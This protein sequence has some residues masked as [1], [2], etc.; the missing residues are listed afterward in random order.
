MLKGCLRS[1]TLSL[2]PWPTIT[3]PRFQEG[4]RF[5]NDTGVPVVLVQHFRGNLDSYDPLI[6][7]DLAQNRELVIFDN[8]GVGRTN[9]A[10]PETIQD[11][12]NDT[13]S[14]IEGLGVDHC[15]VFGH[16]MGGHVS[17]LVALDR[18]DLV[19][20]LILVGTGPRGGEGMAGRPPEVAALW[21]K[22]YGDQD[23]M[24]LPIFF[25]PRRSFGLGDTNRLHVRLSAANPT[26]NAHCEWQ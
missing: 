15:D 20:R 9:G 3:N 5:G 17:Q 7:D 25:T 4:R 24:W 6:L 1:P 2:V 12:A 22:Q 26:T 10:A 8:R 14:F 13:V 23:E 11:L 16:S 21:T 18:P 19:R